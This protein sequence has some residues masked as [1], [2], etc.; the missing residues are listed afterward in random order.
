MAN[1]NTI[2]FVASHLLAA[3]LLAQAG[4]PDPTFFPTA[5]FGTIPTTNGGQARAV[6]VQPDGRIL[7]GGSDGLSLG[8]WCITRLL[9]DGTP[10][11]S[12]GT[13]GT[14]YLTGLAS[15]AQVT[16]LAVDPQGRILATGRDVP[17]HVVRLLANGALD[18]SFG[19]GGHVTTSIEYSSTSVALELVPN[20]PSDYY[21]VVAG[22]SAVRN[23]AFSFAV[24]RYRSNGALDTTGFG[25]L[26]GR[27]G[28]SRTGYVVDNITSASDIPQFAALAIDGSGRIV[29]GGNT[30]AVGEI[31]SPFV[32]ARY[33]AAGALDTTFGTGGHVI[34]DFGVASQ[35][36]RGIAV[37]PDGK[38]LAVGRARPGSVIQTFATR[39]LINGSR[40]GSFGI[41]GMATTGFPIE[42]QPAGGI[43][44]EAGGAITVAINHYT[45]ESQVASLR[46]LANG[47]LD[48][49]YGSGGLGTVVGSPG[50]AE[51]VLG[52]AID[53]QG[54]LVAV[55]SSGNPVS[56]FAARFLP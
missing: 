37:Q 54:R 26:A 43:G 4:A 49:S 38:V 48:P 1:R 12:F 35:Q 52:A 41:G 45:G 9:D 28:T 30:G 31:D 44:I 7:I 25:P 21:I 33:T 46:F 34:D 16:D 10:D 18:T 29:V 51:Q 19:S 2:P 3:S 17:F 40:D 24:A 56:L 15:Y 20:G 39:Y 42:H 27:K 8:R 5:G 14:V 55:G 32:L 23:Q 22:Q 53:G 50:I 36:L 47:Q 11:T 13:G 6:A